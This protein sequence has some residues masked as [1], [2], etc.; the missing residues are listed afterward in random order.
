MYVRV[1]MHACVCDEHMTLVQPRKAYIIILGVCV[2]VMS[3]IMTLVQPY[4]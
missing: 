2:C 4:E 1:H 3:I